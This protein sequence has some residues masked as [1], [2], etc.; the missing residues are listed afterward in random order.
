MFFVNVYF[1]TCHL[2]TF[3][4]L[5]RILTDEADRIEYFPADDLPANSLSK[6][7]ERIWDA[8]AG[9]PQPVFRHQ[10]RPSMLNF[11]DN[12]V[13]DGMFFAHCLDN[14]LPTL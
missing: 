10:T 2:L 3:C 6:H 7:V 13:K 9:Y 14:H 4:P 1:L 12:P 5:D 11:W 8:L